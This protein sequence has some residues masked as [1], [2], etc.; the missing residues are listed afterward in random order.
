MGAQQSAYPKPTHPGYGYAAAP[1]QQ[2]APPSQQLAPP[3]QRPLGQMPPG[4]TICPPGCKQIE[5]FHG[6]EDYHYGGEGFQGIDMSDGSGATI[7]L[8]SPEQTQSM[9]PST[10]YGRGGH[11]GRSDRH[12]CNCGRYC[13]HGYGCRRGWN[14]SWIIVLILLAIAIY[15]AWTNRNTIRI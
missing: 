8:V 14:W 5:S 12:R 4:Q 6:V 9:S 2:L 3:S 7:V 11:R 13:R 15:Y 1:G 10:S